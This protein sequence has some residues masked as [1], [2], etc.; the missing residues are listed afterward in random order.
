MAII[1]SEFNEFGKEKPNKIQF[2]SVR[3]DGVRL[4]GT[5]K[6]DY[7]SHLVSNQGLLG[8]PI[9][10]NC[11]VSEPPESFDNIFQH[12]L[13]SLIENI[14]F[15]LGTDKVDLDNFELKLPFQ[16]DQS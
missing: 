4:W 1:Q 3:F 13:D 6:V 12:L 10:A 15:Y 8:K 5:F 14:R 9:E 7:S 2:E 11:N 16:F